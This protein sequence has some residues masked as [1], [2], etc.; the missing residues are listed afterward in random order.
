MCRL[1]LID[2]PE[3]ARLGRVLEGRVPLAEFGRLQSWLS[4]AAGK[5]QYRIG[6][7]VDQQGYPSLVFDLQARL[8]VTCQRCLQ[9]LELPVNVHNRIRLVESPGAALPGQAD[10]AL[11]GE[12]DFVAA[13]GPLDLLAMIEDE[14]ILALPLAPRHEQCELA[15]G[16][17]G[18]QIES[19]FGVLAQLKKRANR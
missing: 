15:G 8:L 5:L 6:G 11:A 17:I 16:G 10:Q 12:E 14:M 19:P 1:R 9:E 3:F 2:A 7:T 18:T 4:D 13:S